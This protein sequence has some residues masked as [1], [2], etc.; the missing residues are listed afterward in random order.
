MSTILDA[1]KKIEQE[2][3]TNT[4]AAQRRQMDA[5]QPDAGRQRKGRFGKPIIVSALVAAFLILGGTTFY[6]FSGDSEAPTPQATRSKAASPSTAPAPKKASPPPPIARTQKPAPQTTP[7]GPESR[8]SQWAKPQQS[9]PQANATP[10]QAV[11]PRPPGADSSEPPVDQDQLAN[12]TVQNKRPVEPNN[13]RPIRPPT[14]QP[15]PRERT[16]AMTSNAGQPAVTPPPEE[17][18]QPALAKPRRTPPPEEAPQPQR[19]QPRRTSPP[20]PSQTASERQ[21]DRLTDGSL[22][23][24]ALAWS[25]LPDERM[26]VI[27]SQI[28]REGATVDDYIVVRIREDDVVVRREG[29]E[30]RVLIGRN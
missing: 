16:I 30:Y 3:A 14:A 20:K 15:A 19:A 22:K 4:S 6:L 23:V 8:P 5:L 13:A 11:A 26:A 12:Q 27:N 10:Q 18:P 21:I 7:G 28:V 9:K 1:L 2:R 25:S 29:R 17:R 24:Q